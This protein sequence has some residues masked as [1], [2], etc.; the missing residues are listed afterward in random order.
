[1]GI[2]PFAGARAGPISGPCD[3]TDLSSRASDWLFFPNTR[4][5]QASWSHGEI[6]TPLQ[7]NCSS[8][9]GTMNSRRQVRALYGRRN[10]YNVDKFSGIY[11]SLLLDLEAC[12]GILKS[13]SNSFNG[14]ARLIFCLVVALD[15]LGFVSFENETNQMR[16]YLCIT[17]LCFF[18]T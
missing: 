6:A 5:F 17:C 3:L 11:E 9:I 8:L 18:D 7:A 12:I 13:R 10:A 2:R 14:F 4:S 15:N 1:V 16:I